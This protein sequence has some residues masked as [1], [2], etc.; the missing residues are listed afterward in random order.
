MKARIVEACGGKCSVCGYD[1]CI[2]AL[3]F[4]H[5]TDDKEGG[6]SEMLFKRFEV[7]LKEAKKCEL[8]C[9]RCHREAHDTNCNER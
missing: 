7:V 6:I 5:P 1:K 3:E 2:T 9:C 8:L 4:H